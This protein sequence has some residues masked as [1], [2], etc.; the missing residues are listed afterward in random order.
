MV[1]SH[2][3]HIAGER[4]QRE[5]AKQI[6]GDNVAAERGARKR[7]GGYQEGPFCLRPQ[8]D[9]EEGIGGQHTAWV[10]HIGGRDGHSF[11]LDDTQCSDEQFCEEPP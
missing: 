4:K 8:S 7:W 6:A 2:N 5:L 3:V 11:H 1:Q 9:T 10:R